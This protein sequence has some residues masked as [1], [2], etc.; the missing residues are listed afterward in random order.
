[1]IRAG[2]AAAPQAA[3]PIRN[4]IAPEDIKN[5]LAARRP[6]GRDR[7][8]AHARPEARAAPESRPQRLRGEASGRSPTS[9]SPTGSWHAHGRRAV[10]TTRRVGRLPVPERARATSQRSSGGCRTEAG[11]SRAPL[12]RGRLERR[13]ARGDRGADRRACRSDD[14][15]S[16]S[17]RVRARATRSG[18]ASPRRG[19]TCSM[20]LDGDLSVRPEDLPKFY[21]ACAEGRGDL[22]N[23]TRLVYDVEPGAMRFLNMVGN[24]LFRWLFKG[25]TGTARHRH[26]VR[27]EGAPAAGLRAD[28]RRPLVLR[29]VRS[30]RRLRPAPR[31]SATEPEDRRHARSATSRGRTERRT[32]AAGVTAGS[33]SG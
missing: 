32:S 13:D 1:M 27:H 16:S 9:A 10:A 31:R 4:W 26:A 20:I 23:G 11:P 8:P 29:R 19:T 14:S 18:P 30:L 17:R 24:K 3:K 12:R 7:D 22:V 6:R 15:G 25:I 2:R 33:S 5:L 21:R 28:R